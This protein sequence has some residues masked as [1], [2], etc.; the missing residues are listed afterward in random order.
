LVVLVVKADGGIAAGR[1]KKT[2]NG[3]A[4]KFHSLIGLNKQTP[5]L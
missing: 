5:L 3:V 2:S 4:K 1:D